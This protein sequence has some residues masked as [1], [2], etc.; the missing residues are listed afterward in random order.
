[1][2]TKV[3]PARL[4]LLRQIHLFS[5]LGDHELATVD[6]LVDDVTVPP[7][8]VLTTEGQI[9]RQ[10]FIIAS[11]E[12]TVTIAGKRVATVGPGEV[13]GEVAL[14]DGR[15]RTATVTAVTPMQL[16]VLGAPAFQS[17][18]SE[19]ALARRVLADVIRRL[20]E[21]DRIAAAEARGC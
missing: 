13:V 5:G 20:R 4:E 3:Q 14:T 7:G 18:L 12:A 6:R 8:Y 11:G 21:A 10:A 19:S 15:P 2:R 1:M 17:L 9:G 16:L